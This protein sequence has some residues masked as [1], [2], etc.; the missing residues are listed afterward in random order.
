MNTTILEKL[1][2]QE[3]AR[4]FLVYWIAILTA[5]ITYLIFLGLSRI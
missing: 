3:G 1:L 2:G 5:V 4:I